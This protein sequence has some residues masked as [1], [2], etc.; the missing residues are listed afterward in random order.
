MTQHTL[1]VV[2]TG[3][4]ASY[5]IKA[6]RNGGNT[7]PI[8]L[9]PRNARYAAALASEQGCTIAESNQAV[10]DHADTVLLS[11][12]PQHLDDALRDIHF[13]PEQTVISALAGVTVAALRAKGLPDQTVRIMPSSFIEAGDAV[14]PLYPALPTVEALFAQAGKVVVFDDE[15]AFE[16]SVLIA[17]AYAWGYELLDN[18]ANWFA[19]KGWPED[20][21]RDM[22]VR[23]MRGTTTYALAHPEVPLRQILSGIA[24]EGTFTKTG[25]QHLQ[26][27]AAFAPWT[28]ALEHLD[29]ALQA[30]E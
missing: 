11:V 15:A 3:H 20:V 14:I 18:M 27:E 19:E 29:H 2:G 4:F 25:L 21:A 23:H 28:D 10:I 6:L 9:S 22:V 16:R 7:D 30:S 26:N 5:T 17:C 1:G 13:R 24:T 12:R 8:L